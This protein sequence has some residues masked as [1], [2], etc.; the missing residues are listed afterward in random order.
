M[1]VAPAAGFA[2]EA[3]SVSFRSVVGEV[4][5]GIFPQF[6]S[7]KR[8]MGAGQSQIF[9]RNDGRNLVLAI[10]IAFCQILAKF[11]GKLKVAVA[12]SDWS[13]AVF[14]HKT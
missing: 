1:V 5:T 9:G 12:D 14:A 3:E 13:V 7:S 4:S 11:P 10:S 8:K 6:S 2:G